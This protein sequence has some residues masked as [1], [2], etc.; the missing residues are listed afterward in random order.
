MRCG[1]TA[2]AP[3]GCNDA[4]S[5]RAA[6]PCWPIEAAHYSRDRDN[7]GGSGRYGRRRPAARRRDTAGSQPSPGRRLPAARPGPQARR[8]DDV[9]ES[10]T[11]D[12][13]RRGRLRDPRRRIC[14]IRPREL[15]DVAVRVVAAGRGRGFAG[16]GLRRRNLRE[17]TRSRARLCGGRGLV[18]EGRGAEVRP[19]A[20]EPRLPLRARARGSRRIRS[21][22]STCTARRPG[23]PTTA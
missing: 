7:A 18:R 8:P 17:G 22:R 21:R 11:A 5:I 13:D 6:S 14:R 15:C 1:F 19:R 9:H 23:S 3:E 2:A 10:P 16:A 4:R 20:D 12:Q